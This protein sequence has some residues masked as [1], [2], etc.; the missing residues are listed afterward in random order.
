MIDETFKY[1]PKLTF[2][3]DE[4]VHARVAVAMTSADPYANFFSLFPS[5]MTG[6]S[7]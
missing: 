7:K 6:I 3:S 5:T 4:S 2:E 1:G